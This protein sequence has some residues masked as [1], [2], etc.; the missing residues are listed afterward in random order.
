MIKKTGIVTKEAVKR[1]GFSYQQFLK[2]SKELKLSPL[3]Y[4]GEFSFRWTDLQIE[5]IEVYGK[6]TIQSRRKFT[7]V[8]SKL[9]NHD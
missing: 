1:T 8:E 5:M 4:R 6:A 7:I 2:F 9:N 3:K